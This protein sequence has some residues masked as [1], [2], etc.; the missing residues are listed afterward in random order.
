VQDDSEKT[1]E[2]FSKEDL[3]KLY[4]P[5]KIIMEDYKDV[6]KELL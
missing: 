3:I 5:K 6:K 4:N 1:E 2:L